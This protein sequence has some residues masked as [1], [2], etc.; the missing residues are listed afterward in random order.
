MNSYKYKAISRDGQVV[1][2]VV[3][4]YDELE[5]VDQIRKTCQVI[6]SIDKVKEK[7]KLSQIDL[8]EPTVIDDKLLA[9][10]ASQ[11]AILIKA[12]I[13]TSRAVEQI[14][15]QTTD[16]YMKKILEEVSEDVNAG[17]GLAQSIEKRTTKIPSTF[18]E[19]VRAGELSGTLDKSFEKLH[20]YYDKSQK[21]KKKVKSALSYPVL[22]MFLTVV[23]V[24][25]VVKVAVPTIAGVIESGGGQIPLPTRMLLGMYDFF[26]KYGLIVLAIIAAGVIYF[27][28]YRKTDNGRLWLAKTGLNLPALGQVNRMNA[29][30]QFANT[31]STLLGAGLTLT[32]CLS[33]T[34]KTMDNVLVATGVEKS[35]IGIEEGRQLGEVLRENV[36]EL[37]GLLIEMAQA[38]ENSGKLEETLGTIGEYYDS[39]TEY[40][41]ERALAMLEPMLT[42]FLGVI[43]GFIVIALYL[44]MFTM[45]NAM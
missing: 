22:L 35:A 29:A 25:V 3:E 8:T 42:I 13:P 26:A 2:G 44:P 39:E 5:A 6:E 4:A 21:L 9:L 12:G 36:P 32:K 17:Y 20:I 10:T 34:S 30:S 38:G 45:Y 19:T 7:G 33:I 14:A 28:Y 27:I 41:T 16:E 24:I 40:A 15:E 23:V 31:M 1:N 11:F 18:I 43:I 37:P